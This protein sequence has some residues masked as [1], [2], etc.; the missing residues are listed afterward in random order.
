MGILIPRQHASKVYIIGLSLLVIG[1]P[2]SK[3]LMSVSQFVLAAYWLFGEDSGTVPVRPSGN[4]LRDNLTLLGRNVMSRLKRL[5]RSSAALALC[6]VFLLH[7][8]GMAWTSDLHSGWGD[9]RIKLP[10]LLLPLI[11][12]TSEKLDRKQFD[13][14]MGIL[15]AAIFIGTMVSIAVL[16][17][18]IEPKNE[19]TLTDVRNI[20]MFISHIR[21]A[22]LICLS[23]FILGFY[24]WH[25]RGI[26]RILIIGLMLWFVVF[27]GILESI[28][29]L[30]ILFTV[31]L[32]LITWHSL[33]RNS[34][35]HKIVYLGVF[36]VLISGVVYY[37]SNLVQ[38]FNYR[39]EEDLTA[40][41]PRTPRNNIYF[42]DTVSSF[43]E[44]GHRVWTYVCWNELEEEW[45][46]RSSIKFQDKDHRG[47][48]LK[49]TLIRF[50]A[51]KGERK[52][53]DAVQRLTDS[54]IKS[55]E[56]G[57]A[58]VDQQDPTDI[59]ARILGILWELDQYFRGGN[60]TGHSV[61]QRMEYWKASVGII[62]DNPLIGVGTG[63][64]DQAFKQEYKDMRS[65]LDVKNQKRAHNQ[66]LAI[67]VAFGIIGL[68]WFLFALIF[69][70]FKERRVLNYFYITFFLIAVL[71]M[72]TE[73]TLETQAGVTFFAFFNSFFLFSRG[74]YEGEKIEDEMLGI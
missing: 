22:L 52:D 70:M 32:I 11:I 2:L 28:T 20:S 66:F 72:L 57:V 55:I 34:W 62:S 49:H 18:W 33:T 12:A 41:E 59:S 60:P 7:F 29:G 36:F 56:R 50:I 17:G 38:K 1:L 31:T 23:I 48:D 46:K 58:N 64:M 63:D 68:I 40:L 4:T 10:L 5:S 8:I 65:Q 16:S 13:L 21:F 47:N 69:P 54:E 6:S 15:I 51:S 24:A 19:H 53:A 25:A 3:F 37:V 14:L 67:T 30:G 61:S 42:H 74:R 44:N 45:N 73:D 27:L 26:G 71:S 35:A 43:V 9:L 39:V